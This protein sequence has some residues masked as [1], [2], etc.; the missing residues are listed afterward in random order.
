VPRH[1]RVPL[2]LDLTSVNCKPARPLCLRQLP[3]WTSPRPS[4]RTG[5]W[6]YAAEP[7]RQQRP[8]VPTR[9]SN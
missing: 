8:L 2:A 4:A 9:T 1:P 7:R 3:S 5:C 6:N